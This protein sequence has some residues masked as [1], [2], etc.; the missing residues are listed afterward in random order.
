MATMV[1]ERPILF[2]GPMVKAILDGRKT[3]TRRAVKLRDP[4]ATYSCFDDEGWPLSA[5]EYGQ[6]EKDRC[7]Y[8]QPGDRLW[9]RECWGY[10]GGDEYLYQREPGSVGYRA[11]HGSLQPIPG[12]KWKPSIHMPRWASRITLEITDVRV[13]QL[14]AITEEDAIAEGAQ[15]EGFPAAMTNRGAFCRKWS[16]IYGEASWMA[17]PWVWAISFKKV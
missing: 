5:D 15:C 12:G 2:S 7:P 17:N 9:V 10:F 11:T 6:W 14:R 16:E 1:K 4:T 3:Q 8:G 13:E